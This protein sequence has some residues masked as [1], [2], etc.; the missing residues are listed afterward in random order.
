MRNAVLKLIN[1]KD[2]SWFSANDQKISVLTV[3]N[4]KGLEFETV[5]V[6]CEG[7]AVNELY[8]AY[9][10]ALDNLCVVGN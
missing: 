5:A 6:A 8:I 10:R 1:E 2:I 9:T 7:M 4:A 3:E